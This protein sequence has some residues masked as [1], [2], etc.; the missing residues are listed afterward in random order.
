MNPALQSKLSSTSLPPH[1]QVFPNRSLWVVNCCPTCVIESAT[2]RTSKHSRLLLV[3][4]CMC[5]A[6]CSAAC[7]LQVLSL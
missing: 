7:V 4:R 1:T 6:L 2:S 5:N 3:Q